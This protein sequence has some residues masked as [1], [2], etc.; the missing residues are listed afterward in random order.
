MTE[1]NTGPRSE[2]NPTAVLDGELTAGRFV[3][4]FRFA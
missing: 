3:R 4:P 1:I 2:R